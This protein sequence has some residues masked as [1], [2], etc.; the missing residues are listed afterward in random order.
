MPATLALTCVPDHV[1]RAV[2]HAFNDATRYGFAVDLGVAPGRHV[3]L[4]F[5]VLPL[6]AWTIEALTAADFTPDATGMTW[7]CDLGPEVG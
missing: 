5:A 6:A 1:A 4:T 2:E 7:T 3:R